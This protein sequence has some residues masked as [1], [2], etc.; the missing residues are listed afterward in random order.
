MTVSKKVVFLLTLILEWVKAAL[1]PKVITK[2]FKME[3]LRLMPKWTVLEMQ[4]EE[5]IGINLFWFLL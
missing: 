5:Q 2:G 1:W 3:I 4:G